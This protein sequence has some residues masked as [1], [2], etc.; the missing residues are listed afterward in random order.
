MRTENATGDAPRLYQAVLAHLQTG[1]WNDVRNAHTLAW[2]VT[3]LLL[4]QCSFLPAWLP[5][6]HSRATF[7]QSTERRLRRWLENPAIDPTAIY[8]PLVTRALRD[9]GGHTLILALDTSRLFEKFCLIR[10]S[11]LFRGRAVPLVSRVLEHPSA[12]VSTAQLLPVLAEV[13][14]LLDFLGQPE[15]RLLADRGFCDTQLM[16]WLR[17]C[18]WHFRI[19]IKSS[20]ILA[21][22][23]G[24]RLCKVG[25][26]RLAPRETR[27]F[28]NVTLTGQHFGPVHV[29]LGRPMDGPEL[30]QVVSDEP[31]SIETFAEY[32]ER[33]QIE[34][35]FLDEKSGLFGL[36]DS[37][38]R[39]AA[40]LE[41]LI[42]VLTVATLL[43]VSEGVQIVHCGDRRVVDPHW[44][45]AL[46]Y[47]KIG[48]R[49]VQYAL[50]R[51]QAVFTRLTLYG[52]VDPEPLSRRKRPHV[53]PQSTLQVGWQL[54]FRSLS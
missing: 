22:P 16:A 46:S 21:A 52:G 20:L 4:S 39:D 31:T 23:D 37:R 45:R 40:S 18:G 14:G 36:E 15:V 50:S 38:L 29:A 27:Y 28:H 1:L 33:F 48:L 3:G 34:E 9:W 54:V 41:R 12:Q 6:I 24:Q 44:Q 26:V 47:L 25:E 43:L 32:G 53:S 5:H 49:A 30:W 35:G 17:V 42:L 19:R 2:M 7:A 11:V 8:G 13:K 10:V 51:G